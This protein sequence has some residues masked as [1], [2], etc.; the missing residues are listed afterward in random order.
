[1]A[2]SPMGAMFVQFQNPAYI[3]K[4]TAPHKHFSAFKAATLAKNPIHIIQIFAFSIFG[5]PAVLLSPKKPIV[6]GYNS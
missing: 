3:Y 4:F 2:S 5:C 6:S 1:M